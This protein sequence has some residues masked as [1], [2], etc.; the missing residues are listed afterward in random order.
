ML[1]TLMHPAERA[2]RFLV[3]AGWMALI[4]YWSS[5][6]NLPIDQPLLANALHGFQ[7][8]LAHL[9]AFGLLAL[10]GRWALAGLPRA[11]LWAIVLTSAFGALDEWHQSFTGGRHPGIDDW[12]ADTLFAV[13][14]LYAW[15]RVRATS[16]RAPLRAAAPVAVAAMFALGVA[17]AVWPSLPLARDLNRPSLRNV[18]SQVKHTAREVALSTRALAR[19]FRDVVAG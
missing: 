18:P 15:A 11:T 19:Q 2:A 12:A 3:L 14:A 5:Q 8:R 13:L 4:S 17:L 9:A 6:G 10:L 7:H 1:I 16:W